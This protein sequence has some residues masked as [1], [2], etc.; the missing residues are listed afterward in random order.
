MAHLV[1]GPPASSDG[2]TPRPARVLILLWLRP[3]GGAQTGE[4]PLLRCPGPVVSPWSPLLTVTSFHLICLNYWKT[5]TPLGR[6]GQSTR[7]SS[8]LSDGLEMKFAPDVDVGGDPGI[9]CL[10][11]LPIP[12]HCFLFH[13][14]TSILCLL[15]YLVHQGALGP[16]IEAPDNPSHCSVGQKTRG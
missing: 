2:S 5:W 13:L 11:P 4:N 9:H 16:L 8:A 10:L 1:T 14:S 3:C 15:P 12:V 6:C 7:Q